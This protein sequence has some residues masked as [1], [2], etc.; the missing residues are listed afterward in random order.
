MDGLGRK[1]EHSWF[2]LLHGF[3]WRKGGKEA[4][5]HSSANDLA[6]MTALLDSIS[7]LENWLVQQ[8]TVSAYLAKLIRISPI[9]L[10]N[11][12]ALG[13]GRGASGRSNEMFEDIVLNRKH[14]AMI[15]LQCS[16]IQ[17]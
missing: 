10:V 14:L 5:E 8:L 3:G 9:D 17:T 2:R 1:L 15:N 12:R 11:W 7:T 6:R 13:A 4:W 16:K